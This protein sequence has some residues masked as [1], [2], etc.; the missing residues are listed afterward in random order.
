MKKIIFLCT[1]ILFLCNF[2]LHSQERRDSINTPQQKPDSSQSIQPK[3]VPAIISSEGKEIKNGTSKIAQDTLPDNEFKKQEVNSDEPWSVT[4]ETNR[5]FGVALDTIIQDTLIIKSKNKKMKIPVKSIVDI[6]CLNCDST[7][8]FGYILG[9]TFIGFLGGVLGYYIIYNGKDDPN[10]QA[11]FT[12]FSVAGSIFGF[13]TGLLRVSGYREKYY[14]F[15]KGDS[16]KFKVNKIRH[17]IFG[18]VKI[19]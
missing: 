7:Y 2:Y 19:K 16:L 18:L 6:R 4:T 17:E 3:R 15:N 1:S 11:H 12:I 14:T 10:S 9:E 8:Q 5:Y 13:V